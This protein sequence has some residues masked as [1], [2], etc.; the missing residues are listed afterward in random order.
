MTREQYLNQRK[1]LLAQAEELVNGGKLDEFTAK[2]A[3]IEALD[4]KFTDEATAQ[5][6]LNALKDNST[7]K[8]ITDMSGASV[9][10]KTAESVNLG[11][12]SASE[13]EVYNRAFAKHLLG[14]DLNAEEK[15][16]FDM[17]NATQV[18]ADHGVVIPESYVQGI[19]QEMGEQHPIIADTVKTFVKGD[20]TIITGKADTSAKWYDEATSVEESGVTTGEIN[21][22]GYELAKA[23]TVSWKLKEM[24]IDDFIPFITRAIAEVLGN[25]IASAIVSG[26]GTPSGADTFKAQPKGIITALKAESGTPHVVTYSATDAL[27]YEKLTTTM[28]KMK[29][30]YVS[31]SSIYA[32]N[33]TIWNTLAT[34]VDEIGRPLFIPDVT[35]G[36]VGRMFGLIVKEEDAVPDNGMLFGNVGKGYVMNVNRNISVLTED[37]VKARTTDY[38]GYAIMD[39]TTKTTEAFSYLEKK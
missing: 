8:N 20:L 1:A 14:H 18:T 35:S 28:S 29:S 34:L 17:K 22:K 33:N 38:V 16:V 10:G 12:T 9:N 21:L 25:A 6:N 30:G 31:G 7:V 24:S 27:T 23:V 4:Q 36:G 19:W 11:G 32:K 26:L 5:A 39:G 37:H 3:E 13:A 15:N 2:K